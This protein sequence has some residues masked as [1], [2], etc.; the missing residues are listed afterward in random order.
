MVVRTN[1][2]AG[3]ASCGKATEVVNTTSSLVSDS[4]EVG[5]TYAPELQGTGYK[6]KRLKLYSTL[7]ASRGDVGIIKE[8]WIGRT[9]VTSGD[10]YGNGEF[11]CVIGNTGLVWP[12]DGTPG[13]S[14]AVVTIS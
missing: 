2:G 9:G 13:V 4:V 8:C 6:L 12:W 3:L 5:Q 10:V 11:V 14:G 1:Q 7:A